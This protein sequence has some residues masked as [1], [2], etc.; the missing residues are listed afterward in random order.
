MDDMN[1][2]AIKVWVN[3]SLETGAT[4]TSSSIARMSVFW[5]KNLHF[6]FLMD[7]PFLNSEVRAYKF[8]LKNNRIFQIYR[9]RLTQGTW[10][11][12]LWSKH[13][14]YLLADLMHQNLALDTY[15]NSLEFSWSFPITTI[16]PWQ[17]KHIYVSDLCRKRAPQPWEI[18]T[19]RTKWQKE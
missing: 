12:Y 8:F 15:S 4:W 3:P 11:T 6:G 13:N 5:R 16:H 18:S 14:Y 9:L 1:S 17:W 19:P 2:P 7:M 10:S